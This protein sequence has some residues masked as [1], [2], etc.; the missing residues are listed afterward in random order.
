MAAKANEVYVNE[1][2]KETTAALKKKKKE[3]SNTMSER[4]VTLF[5]LKTQV[6]RNHL[7]TLNEKKRKKRLYCT[8]ILSIILS[9]SK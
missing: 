1:S 2:R 5:A 4:K 3:K 6:I 9:S 8:L 7:H